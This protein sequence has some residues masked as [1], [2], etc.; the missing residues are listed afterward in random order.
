M[1]FQ[2]SNKTPEKRGFL[3]RLNVNNLS[4]KRPEPLVKIMVSGH[5]ESVVPVGPLASDRLLPVGVP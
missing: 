2:E 4:G 5:F 1:P 3:G